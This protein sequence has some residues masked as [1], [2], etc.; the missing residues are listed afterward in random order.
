MAPHLDIVKDCLHD[1]EHPHAFVNLED[2]MDPTQPVLGPKTP[3]KSLVQDNPR[4]SEDCDLAQDRDFAPGSP[5]RRPWAPRTR[6][7]ERRL[8]D[9]QPPPRARP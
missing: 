6:P 3:P 5:T 8:G 7:S 4:Y 9:P 1:F 2:P